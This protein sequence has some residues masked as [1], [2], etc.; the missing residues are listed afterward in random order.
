MGQEPPPALQKK[1]MGLAPIVATRTAKSVDHGV[2]GDR[3]RPRFSSIFRVRHKN[4][5]LTCSRADRLDR[6]LPK[7]ATFRGLRFLKMAA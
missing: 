5:T 6:E 2:S 1:I 3:T 7:T 4:G